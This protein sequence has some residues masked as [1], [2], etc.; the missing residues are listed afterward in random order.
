MRV[1]LYGLNFSPEPTGIGKYT[2]E[3]AEWLQEREEL[4]VVTA[5]PYYPAWRI[6]SGYSAWSY[7]WEHQEGMQIWRCPLWVPQRVSGVRRLLHLL[8]FALSSLPIV[9][10]QGI[11]WRPDV[12]M[13]IAPDFFCVPM[14]WIGAGLARAQSWLHLQDFEVDAAFEMELLPQGLRPLALGLESWLLRRFTRVSTIADQMLGRLGQ[15]GVPPERLVLFPNWVDTDEIYP[16]SA[17]PFRREL[18]IEAEAVVVL[19]SGNINQKQGLEVVVEAARR[20]SQ[21]PDLSVELQFVLCGEGPSRG[22]LERLAQD[23]THL[24]FLPLQPK[25]RLNDLLNMADIHLLPQRA[26]VAAVVMPSKLTGIL[27]CGGAV[28]ATA[29]AE[30]ELGR[31]VLQGGGWLCEPGDEEVLGQRIR[32]LALDPQQRQEMRQQARA[33]ALAHLSKE[34]ILTAYHQQMLSLTQGTPEAAQAEVR[35]GD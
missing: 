13:V 27:A 3:M 24:R 17:S 9:V 34:T 25:E 11:T 21:D 20:L 18:G 28:I 14:G 16:L 2:G 6:S 15:K 8:S 7:G 5:P 26:D 1:L 4:R 33:Y 35:S 31:V 30:T 23:L 19:Y 12:V 22:E 29:G 32:Q 10:W